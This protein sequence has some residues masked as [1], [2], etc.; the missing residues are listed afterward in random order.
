[1][2]EQVTH[3]ISTEG[4]DPLALSGVNDS[5][6]LELEQAMGVRVTMRGE[7]FSV[8]GELEAVEQATR[9]A[10]AMVDLARM[11]EVVSPG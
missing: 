2:S 4:A 8:A 1:M 6:L 9:V 3:R 11:G 5:N 7:Q 10:N